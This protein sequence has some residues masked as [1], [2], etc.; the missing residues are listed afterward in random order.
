MLMKQLP[1]LTFVIFLRTAIKKIKLLDTSKISKPTNQ[2]EVKTNS[3]R[4]GEFNSYL[5]ISS[6]CHK[7]SFLTL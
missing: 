4:M 2:I 5:I 6:A 3:V 1:C 7:I